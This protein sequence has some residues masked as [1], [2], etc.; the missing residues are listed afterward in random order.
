[1][2]AEEVM[3]IYCRVCQYKE[4]CYKP[5]VFVLRKLYE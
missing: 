1:M 2:K 4:K 5:C 3:Y